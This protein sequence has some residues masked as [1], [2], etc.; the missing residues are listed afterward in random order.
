M[1][2]R[3]SDEQLRAAFESVQNKSHWK[4]PVNAVIA[5]PTATHQNLLTEAVIH[6]TG[7][8]PSFQD[9]GSGRTRIT[10]PGYYKSCPEY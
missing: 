9:L 5:T 10:A 2:E 6:F 4:K 3:F 1:A 8:A 7:G